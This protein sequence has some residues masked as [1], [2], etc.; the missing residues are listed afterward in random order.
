VPRNDAGADSDRP[1]EEEPRQVARG[2]APST[3]RLAGPS[4]NSIR[5]GGEELIIVS[6]PLDEV[7]HDA[8]TESEAI[9]IGH[10]LSGRTNDEIALIRGV[11]TRTVANQLRSAYRKLGVCSRAEA[12]ALSAG[13]ARVEEP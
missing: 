13:S 8:L 1:I 12:A 9:V 11:S 4:I 3:D 6:F 7:R 5:I 10:V 2:G